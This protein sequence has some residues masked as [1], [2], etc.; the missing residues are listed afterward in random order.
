MCI[1]AGPEF[2]KRAG[3]VL[4]I[5]KALY[6]LK[7]SRAC[8]HDRLADCLREKG[9]QACKAEPDIWLR[10][11]VD[12]YEYIEVYVDDL[13]LALVDP[14]KFMN[15]LQDKR[16]FHLKGTGLLEFHLGADFYRDTHGVLSMAPRKYIERM[17]GSYE[18][19]FGYRS[20]ER[21][22]GK[23]CASMCRYR[24]SPYH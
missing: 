6:G 9:F 22:V 13:A 1:S 3:H 7:S 10:A 23:E 14:K 15:I 4:L 8:W 21:R 24:W 16:G 2:G 20:E 17:I 5:S 19:M 11:S 12:K 18:R